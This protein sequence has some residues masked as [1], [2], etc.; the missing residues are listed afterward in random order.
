MG[1]PFDPGDLSRYLVGF[2]ILQWH[3]AQVLVDGFGGPL[4]RSHRGHDR[5]RS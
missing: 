5:G 1:S 2:E 3:A 4:A